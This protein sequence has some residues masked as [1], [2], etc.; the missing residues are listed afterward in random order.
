M[1]SKWVIK[2]WTIEVAMDLLL[3]WRAIDGVAQSTWV[4]YAELGFQHVSEVCFKYKIQRI[5]APAQ[6]H[7]NW[8]ERVAPL[9]RESPYVPPF[10]REIPSTEPIFQSK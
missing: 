2:A 5:P 7:I 6:D 10:L 3:G 8:A 1:P 9:V 4:T